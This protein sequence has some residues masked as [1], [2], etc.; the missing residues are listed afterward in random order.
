MQD[1][2]SN[3]TDLELDDLI[4]DVRSFVNSSSFETIKRVMI[5]RYVLELQAAE[6][7]GLTATSVHARMKAL[8]EL[9]AEF[10]VIENEIKMRQGRKNVRTR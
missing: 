9:E 2:Y 5:S 10:R 6:V 1:Q 4:S 7:G 8:A 3:L